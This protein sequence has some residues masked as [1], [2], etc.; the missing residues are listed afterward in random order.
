[1]HFSVRILSQLS[2][3]SPGGSANMVSIGNKSD[4]LRVAIAR[5][6]VRMSKQCFQLVQENNHKKGDVLSVARI[7]GI[8]G[9]IKVV[10]FQ[11]FIRQNIFHNRT[12][13]KQTDNY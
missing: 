10:C 2:H 13:V 6:T 8:Q 4:T 9:N 1:M 5:S 12:H 3:V 7:A 11:R